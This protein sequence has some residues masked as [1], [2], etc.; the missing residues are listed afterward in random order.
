M[1]S[2]SYLIKGVKEQLIISGNPYEN[3]RGDKFG[4]RDWKDT[5]AKIEARKKIAEID[6]AIMI[7]QLEKEKLLK[8]AR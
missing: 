1:T 5:P 6:E 2:A 4:V 7:M 8:G 3:L